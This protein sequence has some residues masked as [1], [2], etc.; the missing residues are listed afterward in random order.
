MSEQSH[1]TWWIFGGAGFIGQHFANSVL[2]Q[3]AEDNAVLLDIRDPSVIG[4]QT[5]LSRYAKSQRLRYIPCDVR[6]SLKLPESPATGDVVLN[7]AAVHR[8]PGHRSEEYFATNI[9]GAENICHFAESTGCKEIT[10]T[11][12]ISVYGEHH[13][14]A[15]ED[16]EPSPKTAYGQSKLQAEQIHLDWANRTG[17]RLSIIRPGVVFGPGEGGN[18]TRLVKESLRRQRAIHLKPDLAKAGIYI[19]ELLALMHWLREQ[20][21][22]SGKPLLV[23]GVS[24]ELLYFNDYGKTLQALKQFEAAPLNIPVGALAAVLKLASPLKFLVPATSKF[25]PER[26]LKLTRPNAIRSRRLKEMNYPFSWP[27]DRAMADWL[28][29]GI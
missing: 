11:S 10:F 1:K 20:L 19:E 16:S 21:V 23:N 6:K 12:S 27:L 25:H 4:W 29:R 17:G 13:A 14:T 18:V 8:E 15:D 2:S 28:S 9:K 5:I 24:E 22:D 7:F 3:Y 26:L